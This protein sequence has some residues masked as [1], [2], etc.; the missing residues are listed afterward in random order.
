MGDGGAG[1]IF[2]SNQI[3][4]GHVPQNKNAIVTLLIGER[5]VGTWV[6]ACQSSWASYAASHGFDI[7]L[8]NALPDMS[9]FGLGRSPAWQKLLILEQPWSALYERIVWIDSDIIINR[10]APDILESVPDVGRIG[11]AGGKAQR[12]SPAYQV[13]CERMRGA[14]LRP[15]IWPR[16]A[17]RLDM[18]QFERALDMKVDED[19]IMYN[20]GVMVVSPAHHRDLFSRTYRDYSCQTRL[21]EQPALCYEM[22]RAGLIHEISGRFNWSVLLMRFLYFPE[23]GFKDVTP[24]MYQE[25]LPMLRKELGISYFLHFASCMGLLMAVKEGDLEP[26]AHAQVPGPG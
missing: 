5:Y 16:A 13:L 11:V 21:Y 6:T 10:T 18:D 1:M 24:E 8:V 19:V 4:A 15:E 2:L 23:T 22:H 14:L 3:T 9:D 20:T 25:M 26:D 7:I 12:E 17:L